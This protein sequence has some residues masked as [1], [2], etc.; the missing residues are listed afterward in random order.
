MIGIGVEKEIG[1]NMCLDHEHARPWGL[2]LG[3]H[4]ASGEADCGN[5]VPSSDSYTKPL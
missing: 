3:K 2:A 4:A 5:L 1:T